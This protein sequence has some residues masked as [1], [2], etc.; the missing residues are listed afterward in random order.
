MKYLG[1]G[2]GTASI[3]AILGVLIF[4]EPALAAFYTYDQLGRLTSVRYENG[5]C[6]VY[7]YDATGNRISQSNLASGSPESLVWGSGAWGCTHWAPQQ[8]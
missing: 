7:S 5:V 1:T 2:P 3:L 6:V 4:Q 8:P